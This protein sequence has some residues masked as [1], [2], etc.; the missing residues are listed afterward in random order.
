MPK[1]TYGSQIQK[2]VK[3]LLEALLCFV[4]GEFDDYG[5]DIKYNWNHEDT[6]KP[7]LIIQT[8][9]LTLEW[10]TQ[11][12]KYDGKL[13]SANIRE[14]IKHLDKDNDRSEERRVGKECRSRWSPYH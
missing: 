3:R 2:R 1:K 4:D 11:K 9:L 8:T 5:F 14:A 13:T 6:S 10:L 12:D 7:K